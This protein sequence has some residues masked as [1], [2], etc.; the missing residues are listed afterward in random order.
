[1]AGWLLGS[2]GTSESCLAAELNVPQAQSSG[3]LQGGAWLLRLHNL[4]ARS[5]SDLQPLSPHWI[6]PFVSPS[7]SWGHRASWPG[8]QTLH[9]TA[10]PFRSILLSDRGFWWNLHVVLCVQDWGFRVLPGLGAWG[11]P[12]V[13]SHRRVD[14][15][16]H[17]DCLLGTLL[18]VYLIP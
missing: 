3:S 1:M 8:K 4:P 18:L 14:S 6:S 5:A 13:S 11:A 7:A 10:H 17:Q 12:E 9:V 2:C 16:E 15:L